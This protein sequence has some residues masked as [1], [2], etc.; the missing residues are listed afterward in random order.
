MTRFLLALVG[1]TLFAAA[2][3]PRYSIQAIRYATEPDIPVSA[4]AVGA[5]K[6]QKVD[7][8]DVIR[9]AGSNR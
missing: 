8:A 4:M 3:T 2:P 1:A 7:A 9:R 6:D 5:P